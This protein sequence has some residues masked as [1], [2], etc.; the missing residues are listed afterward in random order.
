MP[1]PTGADSKP[2][3]QYVLR[4]QLHKRPTTSVTPSIQAM[5]MQ[6]RVVRGA[7]P[8]SSALRLSTTTRTPAAFPTTVSLPSLSNRCAGLVVVGGSST[9]TGES[10][11]EFIGPSGVKR[12]VC[13]ITSSVGDVRGHD[14]SLEGLIELLL[15]LLCFTL[16]AESLDKL[17][18]FLLKRGLLSLHTYMHRKLVRQP[19]GMGPS[20]Y[21]AV[22]P[23]RL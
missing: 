6:L 7:Q 19:W 4:D 2:F 1:I 5:A 15:L 3:G 9:R 18:V 16:L 22:C 11:D 21:S 13:L 23:A 20:A 14:L 12:E 8:N 17:V 10:V